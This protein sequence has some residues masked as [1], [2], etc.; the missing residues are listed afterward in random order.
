MPTYTL[1]PQAPFGL[2]VRADHP[3]QTIAGLAAEQLMEWVRAH[4]VLIFRGFEPFDKTQL[5]LYAQRLGEPLQWPFGVINELVVKPDAQN[6]LY[7]P[8]AV[9]LHWDG[10]FIGRKF[11]TSFFF[12][13]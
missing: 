7:T 4:R 2:L 8:S 9:P 5:A 10:A 6:Y 3:G 12:S 1:E 13:A 11:P